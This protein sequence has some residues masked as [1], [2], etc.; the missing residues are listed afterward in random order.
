MAYKLTENLKNALNRPEK[1]PQFILKIDGIDDIFGTVPVD[2][3]PYYD[4]EGI[5]YDMP[6]LY[7]D[8]TFKSPNSKD[9]IHLQGSTNTISQQ[10]EPDKGSGT[11]TSQM[12][13]ELVDLS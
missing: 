7:Y 11:S 2:V 6:G 8:K 5:F 13:F 12:T 9:I 10:I 4:M 3:Y 1:N